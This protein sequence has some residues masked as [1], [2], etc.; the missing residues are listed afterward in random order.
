MVCVIERIRKERMREKK[1]QGVAECP[2]ERDTIG[3]WQARVGG[4]KGMAQYET[5]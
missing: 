1:M 3:N 2:I 5:L 4:S